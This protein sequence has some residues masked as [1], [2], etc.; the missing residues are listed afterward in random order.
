MSVDPSALSALF[1]LRQ[2]HKQSKTPAGQGT[3]GAQALSG[4]PGGVQKQARESQAEVR[5]SL[6]P[7]KAV[8]MGPRSCS[9]ES[10]SASLLRL[11]GMCCKVRPGLASRVS[12]ISAAM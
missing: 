10:Q 9:L 1:C 5:R 11:P 3:P 8:G 4:A 2:S 6:V 12:A 7:F